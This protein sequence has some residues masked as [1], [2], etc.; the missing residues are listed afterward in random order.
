MG[1]PL[2]LPL[3]IRA[4]IRPQSTGCWV[5]TGARTKGGYGITGVRSLSRSSGFTQTTAHRKVYQ[6]LVGPIPP[7]LQL[8]HLCRV[9]GCVNPAHMEVVTQRENLLRSQGCAAVNA[10]K[11]ECN[12]GH[13]LSGQNLAVTAR[14][15][16]CR[17][18]VHASQQRVNARRRTDPA[19]LAYLREWRRKRREMAR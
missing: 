18:C 19:R 8:D 5:W 16:E 2:S 3:R 10:R 4:K 7:G 1:I 15:R 12:R 11:T 9:R 6:L 17:V 13:P 14:G